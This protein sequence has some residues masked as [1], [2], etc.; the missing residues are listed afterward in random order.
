MKIVE[1]PNCF[2][3]NSDD[4][5]ADLPRVKSFVDAALRRFTLFRLK[6][7]PPHRP[8]RKFTVER[9]HKV[10][11]RDLVRGAAIRGNSKPPH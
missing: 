5:D 7:A 8:S 4:S 11:K 10:K 2:T 3:S 9:K 1:C 6:D